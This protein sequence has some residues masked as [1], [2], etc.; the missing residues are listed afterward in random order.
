M[1]LVNSDMLSGDLRV[2]SGYID[3]SR[4][5]GKE[6]ATAMLMR[7]I[8]GL[9][10]VVGTDLTPEIAARHAAAFGQIMKRGRIVI[11]SDTRPTG[12]MIKEAAISGLLSVGCDVV[13]IGV[14]PTPTVPLAVTHYRATAGMA[15]TASHNPVEWN[16]LKFLGSARA[17]LPPRAIEQV[18][19][20][21]DKDGIVYRP[22]N[23]IG[24][25][26]QGTETL[27]LHIDKVCRLKVVDTQ[28]I[29]R[30]RPVV[31]FDGC[32]GAG[33]EYGP[34]LLKALGCRVH[35]INCTVGT[36]FPR[37]AEPVPKNLKALCVAVKKA[38]ADIGFAVDPD[39][40]R[41]AIVDENGIPLGEE[42]TLVLAVYWV[43]SNTPGPV[44]TNMST[45]RAVMDVVSGFG[46]S[47]YT[48]KVGELNVATM[49]KSRRAVIGGE[50]NGGVIMLQL[51]PGRDALLGMALV[52]SLLANTKASISSLAGGLPIYHDAKKTVPC[53]KDLPAR[54]KRFAAHYIKEHQDDRDGIKVGLDDGS[55][56]VRPSNT[57]PIVRIT[58]E[59]KTRAR[60]KVLLADAVRVLGL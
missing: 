36:R 4:I 38:K 12:A 28:S 24:H 39:S 31:V 33:W 54:L 19:A 27:K 18:Y 8:S 1:F 46:Q 42:R 45:T 10:G 30:R 35:P 14:A 23:K 37:G 56:H 7:S 9:R 20:L 2:T 49:M 55:V 41:L 11:A 43:L 44:V 52:L 22:W 13:D 48:S 50:G 5:G 6:E 40:D 47:G 32:G 60:A 25:R 53:P 3:F 29:K 57:E 58:A 21:A 26:T 16:A 59:A 17:A 51:H 34:A 15:I